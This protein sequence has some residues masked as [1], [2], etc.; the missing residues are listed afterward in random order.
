MI[1]A[2]GMILPGNLSFSL[3]GARLLYLLGSPGDPAQKLWALEMLTGATA[4]LLEPPGGGTREDALSLTEVLRRQRGRSRAT[5]ITSYARAERSERILVPLHDGLYVLD[6]PGATVRRIVVGEN[7]QMPALSPDGDRVAF[8]RDG[9]VYVASAEEHATETE[10]RQITRDAHEAGMTNGLAE[11]IAQEELDRR[12]GFWWSPDGQWIAFEEVDERHIPLYVITHQGKETTGPEAREEHR[13][14]FVGAENAHV[15]LGVVSADGRVPVWMDLDF[16][17]EVYLARVFWW[18]DGDLGA[19]VVNRPQ[20]TL[21]LVRFDR[22]TGKRTTVMSEH[23]ELWITVL[24]HGIVQLTDGAFIWV[25]ESSGFRHLYHFNRS[26]MLQRQLTAGEWAVDDLLV[27]DEAGEGVYFTGN[28]EDPREKH[29]YAVPLAGGNVR[30]ITQEP[31]MHEVVIDNNCTQFVDT[32]SAIDRPPTV[33]LRALADG[34]WLQ[35]LPLPEDA[36]IE[37]FRLTPPELVEIRNR[38]ESCSMARSIGQIRVCLG[39]GHTPPSSPSMVDHTP[40]RSPIAG[41]A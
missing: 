6:G 41:D 13:Y 23:N 28:Y 31:G 24:P 5:G 15:R 29:L 11:Y 2:P 17:E 8:V 32:W 22:A 35:T 3:D 19:V 37:A 36:R 7:L 10:P 18:R 39:R 20:K 4:L 34:A 40:R 33:T 38:G 21:W 12:E 30:R 27:V 26:G 14:P 25:S 16:G 1:P 9:E